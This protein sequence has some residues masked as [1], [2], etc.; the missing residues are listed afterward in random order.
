LNR[1]IQGV[2]AYPNLNIAENA[3]LGILK[4][5]GERNAKP[6]SVMKKGILSFVFGN[7]TVVVI[8]EANLALTPK[9]GDSTRLAKGATALDVLALL[10]KES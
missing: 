9:F 8:D 6:S 2:V 5:L 10:T 1:L 4:K 3:V 7:L